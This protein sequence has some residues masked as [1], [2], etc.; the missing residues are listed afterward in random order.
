[1]TQIELWD[2]DID[3]AMINTFKDLKGKVDIINK[4]KNLVEKW[5]LQKRCSK[6]KKKYSIWNEKKSQIGH[7]WRKY[8]WTED[9]P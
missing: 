1:M 4:Q 2:K 7:C 6:T 3:I 8:Q 9:K 5:Q